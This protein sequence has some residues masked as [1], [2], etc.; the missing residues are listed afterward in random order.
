[1]NRVLLIGNNRFTTSVITQVRG[2]EELTV[3]TAS[4]AIEAAQL[5]EEKR[6]EVVISHAECLIETNVI[7]TFGEAS[8]NAFFIVLD[9]PDTCLQRSQPRQ[10]IPLGNR[11]TPSVTSGSTVDVLSELHIEKKIAALEGGAEVYLWL[12]I[13]PE[14][15]L[16]DEAVETAK[17]DPPLASPRADT[18]SW[19][20]ATIGSQAGITGQASI[21]EP[22]SRLAQPN[23]KRITPAAAE[24]GPMRLHTSQCRLI[25]THIH[26]ALKRAQRYHDLSRINAWLSAVA[27]IDALTQLSNRRAFDLELPQQIQVSRRK[28]TPISLMVLDIDYF[29]SVNDRYGHLVGDDVL[30]QLAKRLLANMRF[31]DTPFRYGGEEFVVLLNNT[32]L[33][34][35]HVIA[36]R[37]RH[38]IGSLPFELS[39]LLKESM[40]L[41]I[42]ISIGLAELQ[43]DDDAQGQSLLNRADQYLLQAKATGRN[44]V[45]S[46]Q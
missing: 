34:E 36:E 27:L 37:L 46:G 14:S 12:N 29:K 26:M 42:T 30:K 43:A 1:M 2:L 39:H 32:D 3:M 35:A 11:A 20:R 5:L 9:D 8:Q 25:Q 10:P 23:G 13:Q 18:T 17:M 22:G 7:K 41:D 33:A 44:Q 21:T 45:V 19:A 24:S 38:S 4:H 40:L 31:Y 15:T 6:P 28:S 16:N